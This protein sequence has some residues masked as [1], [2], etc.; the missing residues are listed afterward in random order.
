V[1]EL[2]VKNFKTLKKK[3]KIKKISNDGKLSHAYG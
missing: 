1:K 2:C 3:K